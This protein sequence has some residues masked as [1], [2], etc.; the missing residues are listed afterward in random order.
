[1]RVILAATVTL[2]CVFFSTRGLTQD[3]EALAPG[4]GFLTRFSGTRIEEQND[5]A[6]TVIDVDGTVGSIIDL[7]DPGEE[8]RG[9][10]WIDAP[11][12][13]AVTATDT[14]QVFG[15][16]IGRRRSGQYLSVRHIGFWL[17]P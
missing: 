13:G 6:V 1:M 14:G 5:V 15:I 4:E 3:G 7:R 2:V 16:A 8:P 12:R 17:A 11:R 9:E 10:H